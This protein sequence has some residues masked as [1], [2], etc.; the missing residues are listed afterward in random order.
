MKSEKMTKEELR[1]LLR[2]TI[3]A[4]TFEKTDGSIR[5]MHATLLPRFLPIAEDRENLLTKTKREENP[6]ILAAFDTEKGDWR[7][8]RIESVKEVYVLFPKQNEGVKY[9]APTQE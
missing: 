5:R 3:C 8:F 6:K 9:A 7:S 4:V 1:D 2:E